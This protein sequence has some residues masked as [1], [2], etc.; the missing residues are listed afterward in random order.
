MA[1][2]VEGEVGWGLGRV[3][4]V[5]VVERERQHLL[6]QLFPHDR[7]RL[8]HL[9]RHNRVRARPCTWSSRVEAPSDPELVALGSSQNRPPAHLPG[10]VLHFTEALPLRAERIC[11][12]IY[13]G[14]FLRGRVG[15]GG[16]VM[17]A[18]VEASG[19]SVAAAV[20][21]SGGTLPREWLLLTSQ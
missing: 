6:H 18:T 10:Q 11:F 17:R 2:E 7:V 12:G 15:D 4:E 16:E 8:A 3:G 9:D 21:V 13:F 1:L 20:L 5:G 14:S 19:V